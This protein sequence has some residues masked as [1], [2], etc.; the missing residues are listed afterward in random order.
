MNEIIL[1][2]KERLSERLMELNP[3]SSQLPYYGECLQAVDESLREVKSIMQVFQ[4]ADREEEIGYYKDVIPG[5]L[6]L[7]LYY[8]SVIAMEVER[9]HSS[10]SNFRRYVKAELKE[11]ERYLTK[12]R[13][14]L[15]YY[16]TGETG[17]DQYLFMR[18]AGNSPVLDGQVCTK[19]SYQL[20]QVLAAAKY[21]TTLQEELGDEEGA[22]LHPAAKTANPV[23]EFMGSDAD[24][25]ELVPAVHRMKLVRINGK[26]ATQDQL[27]E[28]VDRLLRRDIRR[29]F[30]TIDSKNRSRKKTQTPFLDR[31]TDAF[32]QRSDDLLK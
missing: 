23:V 29:Q 1:N 3:D 12:E 10:N 31:L 6:L 15:A 17:M 16:E 25:A 7:C 20:A 11:V 30:S 9:M 21:R 19:S 27:L 18:S 22:H 32:I 8:T 26:E 2:I 24:L 4:F 5:I 13:A 28:A 14:L